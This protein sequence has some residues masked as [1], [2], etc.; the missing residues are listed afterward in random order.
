MQ[1]D[2]LEFL[3]CKNVL[4]RIE[5]SLEAP[6]RSQ[7]AQQLKLSRTATS[8]IAQKLI[9][10][11]LIKELE[12]AKKRRGRPGTPLVIDDSRWYAIGASYYSGTWNFVIINLRGTIVA[13]NHVPVVSTD[14]HKIVESLIEGLLYMKSCCPGE[15]IPAF[16]IGAPGLVD[17]RTGSIFRADDLGWKEI[18]PIKEIVEQRTG[19]TCFV[20]NRYRAYGLAEI[21]FGNHNRSHNMIFIGIGT[22]IAGSIY[23]DRVLLKS[24]KYRLGHMVIDPNG[25]L[26]GCGQA[27]CLQAMASEG[28]LIS[29]AR[30]RMEQNPSF[31]SSIHKATLSGKLIAQLA[32]QD[33]DDAKACIRHIAKPL[34][35]AICTLANAIAPDEVIIGGPL[36]DASVYLVDTT[37]SLV[38]EHL[39][40]WQI[41]DMTISK[42]TQGEF[43][44]AVGAATFML[45]NKMELIL[46]ESCPD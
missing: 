42:G 34:A 17:H 41:A 35:I 36:G 20:L 27:G 6:S 37:R 46:G 2:D 31:L 40:D 19:I 14:K 4:Q 22:G 26:C 28:A 12:T 44:S 1:N 39:L 21:R 3:N 11:G 8:M 24:T 10:A 16:G 23:L 9:K 30:D 13:K 33:D 15:M 7:V 43:G 5:H 32:D 18:L 38:Y 25:P 29:Y 45:E